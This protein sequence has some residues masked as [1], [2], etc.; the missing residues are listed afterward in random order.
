MS[1][2]GKKILYFDMSITPTLGVTKYDQ[3]TFNQGN[4]SQDAFTYGIDITQYYFFTNHFA[5]RAD[6]KNQWYTEKLV[7][8][9]G[10]DQGA[11]KRSQSDREMIFLLGFS[12]YFGF[13]K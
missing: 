5:I 3:L 11:Y 8:Y 6:L 12:F 1:F 10:V 7:N 13:T 4:K 2:V 9:A